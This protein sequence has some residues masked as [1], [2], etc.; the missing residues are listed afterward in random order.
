[1]VLVRLP[2]HLE[3]HVEQNTFL[4]LFGSWSDSVPHG[5]MTVGLRLL[6]ALDLRLPQVLE[7]GSRFL[8]CELL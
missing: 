8:S 5:C 2:S 1:M 4:R 3:A 6:S 7:A